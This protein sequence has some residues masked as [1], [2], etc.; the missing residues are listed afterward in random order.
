M[1]S[2]G[3][4]L[5]IPRQGV[6]RL[7]RSLRIVSFPARRGG[8]SHGGQDGQDTPR[9]S[10]LVAFLSHSSYGGFA[11]RANMF[12]ALNILNFTPLIPATAPTDII[13]TGSFGR[14]SDGLAGESSNYKRGLASSRLLN[15]RNG[16][17]EISVGTAADSEFL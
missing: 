6:S 12:N 13:S 14:P 1:G 10:P 15:R 9:C 5:P 4:E 3:Y 16:C 8:Q 2:L 11:I 7:V 17:V